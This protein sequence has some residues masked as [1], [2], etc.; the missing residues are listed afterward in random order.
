MEILKYPHY[1]LRQIA[2]PIYK[3]DYFIK[4]KIKQMFEIL[5]TTPEAVGLAANQIGLLKRVFVIKIGEDHAVFINPEITAVTD[6]TVSLEEECLSLPGKKV[7]IARPSIIFV[8]YKNL[9]NEVV[10]DTLDTLQSRVFQHELDHLNGRLI[11]DYSLE[12]KR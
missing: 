11:I 2:S 1:L 4:D 5:Q 3:I 12:A 8:R 7:A 10:E 9:N 6:G